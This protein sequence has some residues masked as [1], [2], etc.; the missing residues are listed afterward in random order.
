MLVMLDAGESI[1]TGPDSAG[2]DFGLID[3]RLP[4]AGFIRLDHYDSYYPFY[5]SPLD[6]FTADVRGQL[7]SRTGHMFGT[8]PRTAP[9]I[10]G[11]YMQDV[12]G[13]AQG[14]WFRPGTYFSNSTDISSALGLAS[15]Y[16]DPSQPIMAIGSSVSGVTMGLYSFAVQ[17]Q[18]LVNR[19]FREV[20]AD[21][22]TYCYENFL[23]GQSAGGLPLSRPTGVI[24][25]AL[26]ADG[27]LKVE[28]AAAT[29]CAST[30]L[31]SANAATFER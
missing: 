17:T 2:V 7:E 4:P 30:P 22:R 11:T 3:F 8:H 23:S 25:L 13:T 24:L 29:S 19:A 15:D 28:L 26:Q 14:N 31:L 5:A 21:S 1:G 10:G 20:K 9:P 16:V 18:G 6:Y 27:L 12:A